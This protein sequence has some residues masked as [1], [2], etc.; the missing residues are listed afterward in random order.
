MLEG[1]ERF[2]GAAGKSFDA[3]PMP[4]PQEQTV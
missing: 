1:S 2:K 3:W 4:W